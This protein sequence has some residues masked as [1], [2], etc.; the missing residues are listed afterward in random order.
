M[1]KQK[2]TIQELAVIDFPSDVIRSLSLNSVNKHFKYASNEE[3]ITIIKQVLAEPSSYRDHPGLAVLAR[4]LLPEVSPEVVSFYELQSQ[5]T[6]YDVFGSKLIEQATYHQME[7]AMRLPVACK[8]ALM[9]DAHPGFGLPIGGV[10]ATRNIVIPHAVGM[11]IGCRMALSI[12]D[13]PGSYVDQHGYALKKL[14]QQQTHFGNEGGLAVKQEHA[15]LD[16]PAFQAT[17]LL[18]KL[19]GKAVRQLGSSGSGNHFVEFGVLEVESGNSLGLPPGYFTAILSHSG[20]RSLGASVA[21]Y[22]TNVAMSRCKLPSVVKQ[23][24][25]LDLASDAGEEYWLSMNLAGDYARACHDRIHDNLCDALGATAV[26]RIENHHNFAWEERHADGHTYIVHRKGAT[27][28]ANGQYGI[29]PGSMSTPGYVVRGLGNEAS[30]NSAS[31]GAGRKLSRAKAKDSIT[32]SSVRKRLD[33]SNVTLIGGS[34]EEAPDAYKD[35]DSVM[36]SQT[37]LVTTEGKFHP[38]IVRMAND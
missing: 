1:G 23:L 14:L 16:T 36:R 31:H 21:Q 2:L 26:M 6:H 35:I 30:L 7:L 32:M 9:P 28:A 38:R 15:V 8:G 20:S 24:A 33:A 37:T 27:P 34:A 3:K 29:I 11:D 10:L 5:A 22:F 4:K 19:H 18:R 12:L 25:W 17:D 13:L